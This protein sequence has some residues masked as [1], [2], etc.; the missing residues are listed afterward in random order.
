MRVI[1]AGTPDFAV[2]TLEALIAGGHSVVAVYTQPD[3]PAGRG[4]KL[5]TSAVKQIALSH[6]LAIYQP[7]TLKNEAGTIDQRRADVMV[8]VA[9]G[10]MLPAEILTLPTFGCLN[11]HASLLPR[12][13]GAA[14]IQ[15]AIAAG[16]HQS[17]ITI[18]QMDIGLDTGDILRQV[19][20]DISASDTGG[21]LHDRLA[22]LGAQA[23]LDTMAQLETGGIAAT[24]QDDAAA[25]YASKLAKNE[26]VLNWQL[27]AITLER[28][29]RAFNPWPGCR[30]QWRGKSLR[31]LGAR[32]EEVE[33]DN[34]TPGT[35]LAAD[36]N[37]I[38]VATASGKLVLTQVQLAGGKALAASE[39]LNGHDIAVGDSLS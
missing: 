26:G 4:R 28:Q 32:A 39:F 22:T 20:T 7:T 37:G 10:L 38:K 11:V 15:R 24:L 23:L 25:T 21:G 19:A 6:D 29:I 8:V 34:I 33:K 16:D 9:Y 36:E 2:P 17:G 13:R 30:C 5:Q 14:P 31:I 27:E 1:F 3:R 12:W 18:M 35:I